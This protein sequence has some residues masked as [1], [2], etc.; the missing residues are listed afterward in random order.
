MTAINKKPDEDVFAVT[1]EGKVTARYTSATDVTALGFT[2]AQLR[3]L[4]GLLAVT[5]R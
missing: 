5:F 2:E 4:Y 3:A 1:I